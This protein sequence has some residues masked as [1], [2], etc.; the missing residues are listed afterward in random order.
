MSEVEGIP[1]ALVLPPITKDSPILINLLSCL[2]VPPNS[3]LFVLL[4][5]LPPSQIEVAGANST[6]RGPVTH[7]PK[8]RYLKNNIYSNNNLDFKS[9]RL[10]WEWRWGS[11]WWGL[12]GGRDGEGREVE[13]DGDRHRTVF[14]LYSMV[15][16]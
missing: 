4:L 16:N 1:L 7:R 8:P 3:K 2:A 13:D 10:G 11:G 12:E 15:W 6:S 9:S 5:N 14:V